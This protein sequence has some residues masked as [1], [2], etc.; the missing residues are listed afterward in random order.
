[1]FIEQWEQALPESFA[2]FVQH[3]D[4]IG[5]I[6][7]DTGVLPAAVLW[8]VRMAVQGFDE[9]AIAAI[10]EIVG[11]AAGRVLKIVGAWPDDPVTAARQLAEQTAKD[12]TLQAA[13][14]LLNERFDA[15]RHFAEQLARQYAPKLG[16]DTFNL[17]GQIQAALVNI[18]G[19]TNIKELNVALN[20]PTTIVQ[21]PI[22]RRSRI[23]LSMLGLVLL[24]GAALIIYQFVEP[25]LQPLPQMTGTFNIAVAQF[26][27]LDGQGNVV[28]STVGSEL[29]VSVYKAISTEVAALRQTEAFRD[30][31]IEVLAPAD[32]GPIHGALEAQRAEAA[33]KLAEARNIDVII[34]GNLLIDT[35]N[36]T[37]KPEFYL[38]SR[39][40]RYA[41][42]LIG[43]YSFGEPLKAD[44]NVVRESATATALTA[45]LNGRAK[46]LAEFVMG[47]SN[48]ATGQLDKAAER[49]SAAD[50]VPGWDDKPG[51]GKEVLYL[52]LGNAANRRS[53]PT[54]LSLAEKR[55]LLERAH[56]YYEHAIDLNGE[57]S[58]ALIGDA[59]VRFLLARG[60][61]CGAKTVDVAGLRQALD[62]YRRAASARE[63][64][65]GAAI[66][67]KIAFGMGRVYLCL[68]HAGVE[69]QRA[70]AEQQFKAVVADFERD[71]ENLVKKLLA[72]E[73]HANLG[74]LYWEWPAASDAAKIENYRRAIDQY[75]LAYD[76][77]PFSENERRANFSFQLGQLYDNL[78][79]YQQA[80]E[81][82]ADAIRLHP[83]TAQKHSFQQVWDQYRQERPSGA[84]LTP[85]Q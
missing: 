32:T 63:Q 24:A 33:R 62:E 37:F 82:F 35:E 69:D 45:L 36:T 51:T 41:E 3:P 85:A 38:S 72:S 78:G 30:F 12:S 48:Y 77:V 71:Q 46:A 14:G 66:A 11:D 53:I 83:D 26:G 59:E 54:A 34:Y 1:M 60:G 39:R 81:A 80:D 44:G 57:Y 18:G 74:L 65:P 47:L 8:P 49:F 22:S 9:N 43:P 28:K 15:R 55:Q 7:L 58:R 13:L 84:S 5:D 76:R 23:A 50:Q 67:A 27:A 64:P 21:Q 40:L 68:S 25:R 4:T 2:A 29:S 42:E 61:D 73:A 75:H 6:N 79:Q 16:S 10:R 19:T 52:F 17:A 31:N 20:M 70:A 56:D